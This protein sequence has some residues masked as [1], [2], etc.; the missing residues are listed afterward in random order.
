MSEHRLQAL[1]DRI[2]VHD[3]EL[4]ELLAAECQK[5]ARHGS[6]PVGRASD[7]RDVTPR[8]V[9]ERELAFE[10]LDATT[11]DRQQIVE[12]MGNPAGKS[13]H[14]FHLLSLA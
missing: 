13:P 3:F 12:V 10:K 1:D 5:L 6:G 8:R 9:V 4:Q 2:Q 7:Q 14:C 11:D